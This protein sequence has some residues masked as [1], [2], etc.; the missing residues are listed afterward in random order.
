MAMSC[1]PRVVVKENA[2]QAKPTIRLVQSDTISYIVDFPDNQGRDAFLLSFREFLQNYPFATVS[3]GQDHKIVLVNILPEQ[4]TEPGS[5]IP[6]ERS[7]FIEEMIQETVEST[8]GDSALET[9][10]SITPAT[11]GSVKLYL[12]R[13]GIDPSFSSL[14]DV[15]PFGTD[16]SPGFLSVADSSRGRITL[17]LNGRILN[18][19]NKIFSALDI[20]ELWTNFIRHHPS[21][22]MAVFYRVQGVR[23]F[24]EGKEAIVRGFGAT[25]EFT[26]TLR[27]TQPDPYAVHRLTTSRLL[28]SDLRLGRYFIDSEEKDVLLLLP[29]TISTPKR[30]A[31]L[32]KLILRR[33]GDLNPILSFSLNKYDAIVLTSLSDIEY[34]R[35]NLAQKATLI[36]IPSDRYFL[37]ACRS[38]LGR[39]LKEQVDVSDLLK[40]FV[41]AEGNL[42]S[43]IETD[44]VMDIQATSEASEISGLEQHRILFRKD[45]PVSKIIAERLLACLSRVKI[46][47]TL[48]AAD[49]LEY[50]KELV[51]K[52]YDCAVGWVTEKIKVSKSEQLR[53]AAMWFDDQEQESTRLAEIKEIPLFSVNK[54]LLVR[55]GIGLY[56][57]EVGGIYLLP[58]EP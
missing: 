58:Q 1:T 2:E 51:S 26:I 29:N 53:A 54:Y 57:G 9:L 14:L 16:N 31:F 17:R 28:G 43:A 38:G 56:R 4:G 25:D 33:G 49:Q 7:R 36:K 5:I 40:N 39:V 13:S 21:E 55:N 11:G 27:L 10:D 22:G 37:A 30:T 6:F 45:D 15:F 48:I 41:K 12:H 18:G 32:D 3:K 19:K 50:E 8:I 24:I 46:P 47:C 52:G 20:I 44:S 34:A 35:G 23:E 42:I